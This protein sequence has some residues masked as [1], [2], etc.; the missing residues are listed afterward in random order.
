MMR[1]DPCL[2]CAESSW[3]GGGENPNDAGGKSGQVATVSGGC[4]EAS[5]ADQQEQAQTA[6][7]ERLPICN[8]PFLMILWLSTEFQTSVTESVLES[9]GKLRRAF[10]L[11]NSRSRN[12]AF[13]ILVNKVFE[14]LGNSWQWPAHSLQKVDLEIKYMRP[15]SG[16]IESGNT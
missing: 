11:A 4:E 5:A 1:H 2:V 12:F 10:L 9:L 13:L 15:N 16:D 6:D 3:T 7:G 14:S 8:P